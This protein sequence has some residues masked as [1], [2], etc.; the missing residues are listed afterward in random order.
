MTS[1]YKIILIV[2]VLVSAFICNVVVRMF[3]IGEQAHRISHLQKIV[4][5]AGK[6]G[7]S[8]S[9]GAVSGVVKGE[10][11]VDLILSKIP[12]EARVTEYASKIGKLIEKNQLKVE[13][14]LVFHSGKEKHDDLV[15]YK[16]EI[17]VL[18]DYKG[19]KKFIADLQN[20]PGLAYLS[21]ADFSRINK[22]SEE[23]R[24]RVGYTVFFKKGDYET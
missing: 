15:E 20:M 12:G 17:I 11:D 14:T 16:A 4:A 18:G 3:V 2:L 13:K 21:S 6:G 9:N 22:G 10:N 19:I 24:F 5:D 8:S 1:K 23:I 7:S